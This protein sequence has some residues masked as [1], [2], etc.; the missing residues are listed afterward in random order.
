MVVNDILQV[1]IDSI[2]TTA[3]TAMKIEKVDEDVWMF[4][5]RHQEEFARNAAQSLASILECE[6]EESKVS[7]S[8]GF[9]GRLKRNDGKEMG[10]R[11]EDI[12]M[13]LAALRHVSSSTV[14]SRALARKIEDFYGE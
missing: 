11:I 8:V 9:T 12:L 14:A 4:V 7:Q 2:A 1:L 5:K 6:A 13:M 10:L 3:E